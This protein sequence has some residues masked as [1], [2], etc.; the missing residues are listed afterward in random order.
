MH[1][2]SRAWLPVAFTVWL[3]APPPMCRSAG[4]D[5]PAD[6]AA[7]RVVLHAHLDNVESFERLTCRY[8]TT[9]TYAQSP[10]DAVAG[11][12]TKPTRTGKFLWAM[13]G[14]D[15]SIKEVEDSETTRDIDHPKL[16]P[17]PGRPNLKFGPGHHFETTEYLGA[18]EVSLKF[19]PRGTT[20]NVRGEGR[21]AKRPFTI[22]GCYGAEGCTD[23]LRE[24]LTELESDTAAV[25]LARVRDGGRELFKLTR[26]R[27]PNDH[28]EFWLDPA[29]GYLFAR[30]VVRSPGATKG[31]VVHIEYLDPRACPNGRWF[32][33]RRVTCLHQPQMPEWLV[34]D[35]RV[36][37]LEVDR[38][39]ARKHFEVSLPAGT[40]V[41]DFDDTSHYFVT[42]KA[43]RVHVDD[44]PRIYRMTRE[45]A[46]NPRMDTA[47]VRPRSYRWAW[48][49][50]GAAATVLAV[51]T[52]RVVRSRRHNETS[53]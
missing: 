12:Y 50:A 24:L 21:P 3:V 47:I 7:V 5:G 8:E 9:V 20:V 45:A 26:D 4:P 52:W 22:L 34:Y 16:E 14:T 38:K 2:I 40:P 32:P 48:W 33:G 13:D 31:T 42:R 46:E 17:V 53:P 29:H 6:L 15:T 19:T 1:S 30:S 37:E 35:T 27:G 18:S 28:A 25:V 41:L 23:P 10:A 49:A 43:E 11:R 39:P 51:L 36:T 44:L